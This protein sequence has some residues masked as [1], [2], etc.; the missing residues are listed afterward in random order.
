M[1]PLFRYTL[2]TV[3]L[4]QRYLPPVLLFVGLM[5]VFTSNDNGSLLPVYAFASAAV[6]VCGTWL[7][8]ATVHA[9]DP[10]QRSITVVNAGGP[11]RVL[12]AS[13][14]VAF[15]GCAALGVLGLLYP[16]TTGRHSLDGV[17]LV[18][19]LVAELTGAC[20]GIAVGLLCSRLVIRRLGYSVLV[21][22]LATFTL[23][24]VPGMPPMNLVFHLMVN[25]NDAG[26]VLLPTIGFAVLSVA[27]AVAGTAI[28]GV[29]STRRD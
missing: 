10:V 3:L 6:F 24:L 7:T 27:M 13:V 1:I 14:G 19:G 28:A 15:T 29:V 2:T 16:L 25:V 23:L 22:L 18:V 12:A 5:A 11:L 17:V 20:S 21:A 9:E 4:S 8:I 26:A